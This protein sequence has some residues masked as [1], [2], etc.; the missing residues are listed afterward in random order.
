MSNFPDF[1]SFV[2]GFSQI[3]N[4]VPIIMY[5]CNTSSWSSNSIPPLVEKSVF[6]SNTLSNLP[7]TIV[8]AAWSS[9]TLSN[10]PGIVSSA[11][12]SSNAVVYASNSVLFLSNTTIWAS[13][14]VGEWIS[15]CEY[16]GSISP[17]ITS[18]A[19]ITSATSL[20]VSGNI[21]VGTST[22]LYPIHI[23]S[24][25]NVSLSNFQY[26]AS[27][28]IGTSPSNVTSQVSLF[29][30]QH[31]VASQFDAISDERVKNDVQDMSE[32][33]VMQVMG[34]V[35]PRLYRYID[36]YTHG[37]ATNAGFIAQELEF[38]VGTHIPSLVNLQDGDT[39]SV[40]LMFS[41]LRMDD[42]VI[43]LQDV[44]PDVYSS[45]VQNE[46]ILSFRDHCYATHHATVLRCV[47]RYVTLQFLKPLPV[48]MED[49]IFCYG[50]K[51][52]NLRAV[53]H[54]QIFAVSVAATKLLLA[55]VASQ[56][57]IISNLVNEVADL[58]QQFITIKEVYNNVV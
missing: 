7:G 9:N 55:K 10:Q 27:S 35:H 4:T 38:D 43:I 26:L 33:L 18:N 3:V 19:T 29:C 32:D 39:P 45:F 57:N 5:A 28:G 14:L 13:N 25:S 30:T 54:K 22:P 58:Q 37:A 50:E 11:Q 42:N 12:F 47:D 41:F 51:V 40:M 17:T 16:M 48:F 23:A 24:S 6:A 44:D 46:T 21:G 49:R 31:V 2:N 15:A 53:D 36:Q 1:G 20:Y 52:R 34:S 8:S 56:E